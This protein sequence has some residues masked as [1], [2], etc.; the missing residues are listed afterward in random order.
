MGCTGAAAGAGAVAPGGEAAVGAGCAQT[1]A[2]IATA[3]AAVMLIKK[4]FMA[5]SSKFNIK[6]TPL[7]E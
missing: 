7:P 3:A 6:D 4:C 1:G 2:E 5:R